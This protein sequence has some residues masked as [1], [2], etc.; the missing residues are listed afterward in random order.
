[1]SEFVNNIV[2]DKLKKILK[3]KT[4]NYS[5]IIEFAY[6]KLY[7]AYDDNENF[8]FTNLEGCLCLVINRKFSCLN[9]QLFEFVHYKKEFEIELYT[10]ID[11]GYSVLN[12]NFHSIEFPNFFLGINFANKYNAEKIKNT[13]FFNSIILNSSNN[14]FCLFNSKKIESDN[15]RNLKLVN[16]LNNFGQKILPK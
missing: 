11:K 9:L 14:L 15:L 12:D 1:M 10:N 16:E 13:I 8:E 4:E 7:I 5:T 3:E 2:S 6:V